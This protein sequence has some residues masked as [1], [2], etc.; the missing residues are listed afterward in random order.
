MYQGPRGSCLMK[1]PEAKISCQGPLSSSNLQQV[2][3]EG[4]LQYDG[5]DKIVASVPEIPS[6]LFSSE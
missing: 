3:S 2:T 4:E 6:K 5:V 1:K